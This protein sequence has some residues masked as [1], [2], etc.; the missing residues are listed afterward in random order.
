MLKAK[1]KFTIAVTVMCSA[2]LILAVACSIMFAAFQASKQGSTTI[3]FHEGITIDVNGIDGNGLWYYNNTGNTDTF[4]MSSGAVLNGLAL[5]PISVTVTKGAPCYVRIFAVITTSSTKVTMPN[6]SLGTGVTEDEY[7]SQQ[8]QEIISDFSSA[9]S[10]SNKHT[11]SI[12]G[13]IQVTPASDDTI[14]S[15]EIN[16]L[17]ALSVFSI[18][19][20]GIS[21]FNGESVQAFFKIYATT[22]MTENSWDE[23]FTFSFSVGN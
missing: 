15:A 2:I 23:G 20:N 16:L 4:P 14:A 11:Q 5:S 6:F 21:D 22:S 18:A 10:G 9:N 19:E 17:Q 3:S 13:T 8:E 1:D 12:A 7:R